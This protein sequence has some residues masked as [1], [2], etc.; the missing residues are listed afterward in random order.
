[1]HPKVNVWK[2][3]QAEW[4]WVEDAFEKLSALQN[5]PDRQPVVDA[6]CELIPEY[7]PLNPPK[8]KSSTPVQSK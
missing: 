5:C 6:L 2:S 3:R 7:E 4:S 1:V 8:K